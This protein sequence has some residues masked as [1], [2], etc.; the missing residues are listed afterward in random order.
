MGETYTQN[1]NQ[2]AVPEKVLMCELT[3]L[4]EGVMCLMELFKEAFKKVSLLHQL[5][6]QSWLVSNE[7]ACN[8]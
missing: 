3:I 7:R 6:H 8:H 2:V 5:K 1:F 4:E